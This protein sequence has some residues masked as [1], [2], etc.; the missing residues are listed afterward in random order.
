MRVVALL[1][2]MGA[3][4]PVSELPTTRSGIGVATD[5]NGYWYIV[6]FYVLPRSAR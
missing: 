5:L 2:I 4:A 3:C 1:L 6:Q